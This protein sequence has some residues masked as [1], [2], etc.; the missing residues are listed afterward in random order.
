MVSQ[1]QTQSARIN[2]RQLRRDFPRTFPVQKQYCRC[3][4]HL[5]CDAAQDGIH[6]RLRIRKSEGRCRNALRY[7]SLCFFRWK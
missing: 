6:I 2:I 5:W 4:A 3:H 7:D 1:S